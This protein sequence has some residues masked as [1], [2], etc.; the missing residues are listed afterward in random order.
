[1]HIYIYVYIYTYTYIHIHTHAIILRV[2]GHEPYVP[3][4]TGQG[5][6]TFRRAGRAKRDEDY[7]HVEG[8]VVGTLEENQFH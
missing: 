3:K 6:P 4:P 1:M 5:F 8:L 2:S 7:T